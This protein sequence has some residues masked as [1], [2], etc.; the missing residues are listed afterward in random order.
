[1]LKHYL[2]PV[3]TEEE[4]KKFKAERENNKSLATLGSDDA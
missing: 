3:L 1:M 2:S 4:K